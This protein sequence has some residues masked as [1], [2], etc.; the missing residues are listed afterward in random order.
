MLQR[1]RSKE[2]RWLYPSGYRWRR[3]T[4]A[5]RD[6]PDFIVLGTMKSG[7]TSFFNYLAQ[8]PQV[9]PP[10]QKAVRYFSRYP[11]QDVDWYRSFFPMNK[12]SRITGEASPRYFWVDTA[13]AQIKATV[14]DAKL[15]VLLRNPIDR[16]FSQYHMQTKGDDGVPFE[17]AIDPEHPD[18]LEDKRHYLERGCYARYAKRWLTL[19]PREQM[20]FLHF[21]N[22]LADPLSG[23][24]SVFDFL[25][26]E[27]VYPSDLT[28]RVVG[29]YSKML[30]ET[31]ARL[32]EHFREPNAEL[33]ELLG[34]EFSWAP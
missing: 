3:L 7:T 26:L 22:F 23:M 25:G 19:F 4:A 8:H 1:N 18:Y 31:R 30:P 14:P 10:V 12:G 13:P 16:A 29:S 32:N 33:T 27:E 28:P 11:D 34:P 6:L 2:E 20:L 21:E 15:I 17:H 5:W 24:K 9:A